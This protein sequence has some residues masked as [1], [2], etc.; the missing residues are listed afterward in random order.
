MGKLS[1]VP[2]A[3]TRRRLA[4]LPSLADAI[5]LLSPLG[6]WPLDETSGTTANDRSGN[7]RNGTYSQSGSGGYTLAGQAGPDGRNYVVLSP[8]TAT[9]QI[10]FTDDNV[11]SMNQASGLTIFACVMTTVRDTQV[12][13]IISKGNGANQ[14]EWAFHINAGLAGRLGAH[15]WTATGATIRSVLSDNSAVD[16][17]GVWYAVSLTCGSPTS[18][19]TIEIRRNSN[20]E[21]SPVTKAGVVGTYANGTSAM[22]IGNRA[23]LPANQNWEGAIANVAIFAGIVDLSSVF[24]AADLEGWF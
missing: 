20:T 16:A 15:N 12:R 4:T 11:W 24:A 19:S 22:I 18:T 14:Y 17:T 13:N 2:H 8:S 21:L 9:G 7:A 10:D 3:R 23:D 5:K 1:T 6:Y